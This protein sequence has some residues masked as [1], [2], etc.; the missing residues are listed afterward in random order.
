[1]CFGLKLQL[2]GGSNNLIFSKRLSIVKILVF[3]NESEHVQNVI[4]WQ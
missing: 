2:N 4:Q 1:M 3:S